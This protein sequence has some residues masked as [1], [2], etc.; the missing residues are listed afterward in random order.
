[1]NKHSLI[2]SICLL[3]YLLG[4][5]GSAQ[6]TVLLLANLGHS[7]KLFL[8]QQ[9]SALQITLHHPGYID[10]HNPDLTLHQHDLLDEI[11][12]TLSSQDNS[13]DCT[14]HIIHIPT[15]KELIVATSNNINDKIN[16]SIG[17]TFLATIFLFPIFIS[18]VIDSSCSDQLQPDIPSVPL[19]LPTTVLL[20]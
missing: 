8:A 11:I 13:Y 4:W 15:D 18:K 20:N 3:A 14:D 16:L 1:M 2:G 19:H 12:F 5:L 17:F 9:G 7:H 10:D 6:M